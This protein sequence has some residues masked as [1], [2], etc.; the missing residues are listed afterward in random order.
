MPEYDAFG[1]EIGENTLEGLGGDSRAPERASEAAGWEARAEAARA[2]AAA[3]PAIP[4]EEPAPPPERPSP[5]PAPPAPPQTAVRRRRG[6]APRAIGCLVSLI[7]MG[8][9]LGVIGIVAAGIFG[10][11]Q[12]ALDDVTDTLDQVRPPAELSGI[13]GASLIAPANL[14]PKLEELAQDGRRAVTVTVWPERLSGLVVDGR[15]QRIV[16]LPADGA[17][18]RSDPQP[19]NPAAPSFALRALDPEAP[20]RLVRRS[21]ARF[22]VRPEGINYLVAT[23]DSA[24]GGGHRWVAYFKNGIYVEGDAT[25]KVTRRIS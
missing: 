18:F 11:A 21:A 23:P 19:A 15:R 12:N 22:A 7:F 17:V 14:A 13:T 16:N 8:L 6:A 9:M 10:S 4:A 25:G 20:A 1:R 3:A 5:A 24:G 2:Q